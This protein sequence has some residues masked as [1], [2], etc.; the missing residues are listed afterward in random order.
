MSDKKDNSQHESDK[1]EKKAPLK[2]DEQIKALEGELESAKQKSDE[3]WD[4]ALRAVAELENTKRRAE[5]DV[6]NAHKF[7]LERFAKDLLPVI[8]SLE[9]ALEASQ[10]DSFK[11]LREGTELTLKMFLDVVA[12]HGLTQIYPE[13]EPF[14]PEQHEAMT[15]QP[16]TDAEPNTVV[17]VIQRGYLL[18]GRLVRP[19]RVVVAQ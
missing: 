9:K 16:G 4:K 1:A 14:N 7:A 3:N 5:R 6:Q 17:A 12:K 19:A 8:D 11:V 10:E 13:G 18:N 15:M 2:F